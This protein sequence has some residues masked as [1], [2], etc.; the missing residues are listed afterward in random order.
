MHLLL[1]MSRCDL[2]HISVEIDDLISA[3]IPNTGNLTSRELV[4]KWMFHNLFG[5]FNPNANCLINKN[6]KLQ[7]HFSFPMQ[8]NPVVSLAEDEKPKYGYRYDPK[9]DKMNKKNF[10]MTLLFI[11][12]TP[13][14]T[15]L[16]RHVGT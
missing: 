14:S 15:E 2:I 16:N 11:E 7:C 3:E 10:H 6:G 4:L 5:E 1:I 8:Y 12:K 9:L 13:T